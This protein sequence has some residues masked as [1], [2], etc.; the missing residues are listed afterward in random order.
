[1]EAVG[2]KNLIRRLELETSSLARNPEIEWT[3]ADRDR[4]YVHRSDRELDGQITDATPSQTRW[5]SI[6]T[7]ATEEAEGQLEPIGC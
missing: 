4:A 2:A 6:L 5:R 7:S 3:V 1:M